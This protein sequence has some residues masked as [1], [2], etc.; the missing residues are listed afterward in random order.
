MAE[1]YRYR[2]TVV[3]DTAAGRRSGSSVIQVKMRPGGLLSGYAYVADYHGEAVAIDLPGGR[4]LYALLTKPQASYGAEFYALAAYRDVLPHTSNWRDDIE[5]LQTQRA[6]ALLGPKD[7]P[8]LVTF[9]DPR[10]PKTVVPIE[11]SKLSTIFGPGVRLAHIEIAITTDP[12]TETIAARLPSFGPET[13]F[14]TWWRQ[15]PYGDPR[16]INSYDF[17]RKEN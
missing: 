16:I 6:P 17:R 11:P 10:D 9:A 8:R 15:L 1:T 7:Y 13:G 4:T 12:V 5:A 2:M 14:P 3:V